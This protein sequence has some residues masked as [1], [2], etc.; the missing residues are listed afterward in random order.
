MGIK[1]SLLIVEGKPKCSTFELV[2]SFGF[3]NITFQD[4]DSMSNYINPEPN[5]VAVAYWNNFTVIAHETLPF[6]MIEQDFARRRF[7]HEI[8]LRRYFESRNTLAV[9]LHSVTNTYGMSLNKDKKHSQLYGYH[10]SSPWTYGEKTQ[11]QLDYLK[12]SYKNTNG[13]VIYLIDGE[14]Y[15]HD[16]IGEDIILW[17]IEEFVGKPSGYLYDL[18]AEIFKVTDEHLYYYP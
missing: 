18:E 12:S 7:F 16:Q 17:N 4:N 8:T 5:F 15:T 6:S 2:Q 13:E 9:L 10:G 14:K 1:K 11:I 3:E